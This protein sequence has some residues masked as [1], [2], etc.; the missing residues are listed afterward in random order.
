MKEE[1]PEAEMPE[2]EIVEGGYCIWRKRI[3][4]EIIKG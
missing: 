3:K 1:M 4:E 2:E